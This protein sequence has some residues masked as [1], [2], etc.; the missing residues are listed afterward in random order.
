[1]RVPTYAAIRRTCTRLDRTLDASGG[2]PAVAIKLDARFLRE[3][4]YGALSR[5]QANMLLKAI[6]DAAE[7]IVGVQLAA[8]MTSEQLDAFE[9]FIDASDEAGALAWLERNFSDYK[10][11]VG[12]VM[13][14]IG[15][16]LRATASRVNGE[17]DGS[18][19]GE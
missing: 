3:H 16:E 18:E 17:A 5:D 11:R 6:Y 7:T 12:Q 13:S 10:E 15:K 8:D 2:D 4:G 9:R 1:M 14:L 19:G